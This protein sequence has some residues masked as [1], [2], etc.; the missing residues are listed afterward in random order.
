MVNSGCWTH[1]DNLPIDCAE[2][3]GFPKN[4][5]VARRRLSSR[6]PA[7]NLVDAG[8]AVTGCFAE[9]RTPDFDTDVYQDAYSPSMIT[10]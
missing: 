9:T 8:A 5:P 2:A 3:Q 4:A 7:V 1:L 6:T 10:R